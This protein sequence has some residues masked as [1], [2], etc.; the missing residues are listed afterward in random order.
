MLDKNISKAVY[1]R[2]SWRCRH[3]NHRENLTP[4]HIIFKS[5]QG[6]D[7]FNNLITLCIQCHNAVHDG[8]LEI[9]VLDVL[10]SNVVVS[11]KRLKGWKPI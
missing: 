6:T 1:I 9:I 10:P 5:Q 7:N 8:K 11:F 3:C 2:D 4:H